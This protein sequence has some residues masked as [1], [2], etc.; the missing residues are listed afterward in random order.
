MVNGDTKPKKKKTLTEKIEKVQKIPGIPI[1]GNRGGV[2]IRSRKSVLDE[3]TGKEVFVG[4]EL[5]GGAA[6]APIEGTRGAITSSATGAPI[7]ALQAGQQLDPKLLENFRTV[8]DPNRPQPLETFQQGVVPIEG[9]VSET[10]QVIPAQDEAIPLAAGPTTPVDIFGQSF[11]LP[12]DEP[13]QGIPPSLLFG[14]GQIATGFGLNPAISLKSAGGILPKP[15]LTKQTNL[16]GDKLRKTISNTKND[17]AIEGFW[18]R[19]LRNSLSQILSP[20]TIAAIAYIYKEIPSNVAFGR[21]VREEETGIPLQKSIDLAFENNDLLAAQQGIELQRTLADPAL[22]QN[23]TALESIYSEPL[24]D[25]VEAFMETTRLLNEQND[26][27]L[28]RVVGSQEGRR[29]IE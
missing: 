23:Y 17:R 10:E 24:I 12:V 21:F 11:L 7:R 6:A 2:P 19:V 26:K 20:A 8:Q 22:V 9:Q 25:G 1:P 15:V 3:A 29:L 18:R 13:G 4:T 5:G 28:K 27:K 16:F 14:G